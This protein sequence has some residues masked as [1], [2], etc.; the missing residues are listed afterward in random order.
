M[1]L[2]KE[3][4]LCRI[5]PPGSTVHY[6]VRHVSKSGMLSEIALTVIWNDGKGSRKEDIT[7]HVANLLNYKIGKTGG[8]RMTGTGMDI[9]WYLVY[10]L[11]QR[12]Y[13]GA[14]GKDELQGKQHDLT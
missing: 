14:S 3:E 11:S 9:G 5:L 10:Q 1:T 7:P 12:L 13:P 8:I 4:D 6:S 2:L